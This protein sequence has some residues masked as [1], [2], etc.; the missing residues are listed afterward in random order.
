MLQV[1]QESLESKESKED[2]KKTEFELF[3]NEEEIE[4]RIKSG[5]LFKG[6]FSVSSNNTQEGT[7]SI[8]YSYGYAGDIFIPDI[9]SR[10]RTI[11]GDLVAVQLLPESEW[12]CPS[13]SLKQTNEEDENFK[14]ENSQSSP[15]EQE[16]KKHPT[17][18]IVGVIE[19]VNKSYVATIQID[20]DCSAEEMKTKEKVLCVPLDPKIPKIRIKTRQTSALLNSRIVVRIDSWDATS[21]YPFGHYI[22]QLGELGKL[23]TETQTIL[24]DNGIIINPFSSAMLSEIPSTS[25]ENPWQLP[26]EEIKKRRDLRKECIFS[27]DPLGS[28]DIDDA[29]SAKILP[30]GNIQIGCHIADVTYFLQKD[31]LLDTEAKAR[32]TTVYLAETRF[33]MLPGILSTDLASLREQKDRPAVSV[34]WELNSQLE[35]VK[36]WYGRTAIRSCHELYYE[37][38]QRIAD[39]KMTE[40]EKKKYPDHPQLKEAILLLIKVAR[41]FRE[42]RIREG[43]LELE[44]QELRFVLNQNTKSPEK[45]VAKKSQEINNVVAEFM[46]LANKHV[47]KKI[48]DH[49]PSAALLRNHPPPRPGRFDRLNKL[50]A[51]KG[52]TLDTRSN[53]T[54]AKSLDAAV[55]PEDPTFNQVLRTLAT[56]CVESAEYIS[57]GSHTVEE[58]YHFGLAANF[59]THFTS[60]IRRYADVVVHRQLLQA[61]KT[62]PEEPLWT[63]QELS[64]LAAHIN[65][66][67][68]AAKNAQRDSSELFQTLF[69]KNRNDH[70]D[71]VIYDIRTNGLLIFLPK[72]GIRGT[73]YLRGKDGTILIPPTAFPSKKSNS[74]VTVSNY[75]I[76]EDF[77]TVSIQ[78]SKGLKTLHLFDHFI[79]KILVQ[80][81]RAHRSTLKFELVQFTETKIKSTFS[82]TSSNIKF[83][84]Q[85]MI[86]AIKAKEKAE[87]VNFFFFS[88]FF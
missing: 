58:F 22:T 34:I 62:P 78:T 74:P 29:L 38:A 86:Q 56:Q 32:G 70:E 40:E 8:P 15:Q 16:K 84:E 49:Y 9:K 57:T 80:E 65:T 7:V 23:E 54:L 64:E 69:F 73:V 55:I 31:S 28:E 26:E 24:V 2:Q 18:K 46:I 61:L 39:D 82:L 47:A 10:N 4:I 48:Y 51:S 19:R 75:T 76:D 71:A 79:V 88:S 72:Y 67:H 30:S 36:A 59:Y 21:K 12:K 87:R 11:H 52:F 14:D 25:V 66:Q 81:S 45:I 33:D 35:I 63:D 50:A 53:Y 1:Y 20:K 37:L 6:K 43:A 85:D 41:K 3:L 77:T 42:E 83:K 27:I 13:S 60:P 17:G 68:D 5:S 44:S